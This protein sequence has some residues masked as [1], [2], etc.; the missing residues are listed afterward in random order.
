MTLMCVVGVREGPGGGG[1]H[2]L[3]LIIHVYK[4]A[5]DSNANH[6]RKSISP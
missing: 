3:T 6:P 2:V 5:F 1:A 4:N